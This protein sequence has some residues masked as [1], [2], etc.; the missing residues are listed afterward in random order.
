MS[1]QA[2]ATIDE[3]LRLLISSAAHGV[4]WLGDETEVCCVVEVVTAGLVRIRPIA[5]W[6]KLHSLA[7]EE[8]QVLLEGQADE[9]WERL[10]FPKAFLAMA[11]RKSQVGRPLHKVKLPALA[12]LALFKQRSGP[13]LPQPAGRRKGGTVVLRTHTDAIELM[14][15]PLLEAA[16][17]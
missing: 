2:L 7:P 16:N 17:G 8:A 1:G 3:K 14:G 6:A 15:H 13:L 5:A 12:I 9:P 11:K 4:P 10:D